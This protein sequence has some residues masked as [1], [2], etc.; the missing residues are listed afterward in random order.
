MR[1]PSKTSEE[2]VQTPKMASKSR[3]HAKTPQI[4]QI[5][6]SKAKTPLFANNFRKKNICAPPIRGVGCA[7]PVDILWTKRH[8]PILSRSIF[9]KKRVQLFAT[10]RDGHTDISYI[11]GPR[12]EKI[13][14]KFPQ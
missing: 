9:I 14:E 3:N 1:K 13:F 7:S 6:K 12:E 5:A 11:R 4:L 8:R 2:P 10:I